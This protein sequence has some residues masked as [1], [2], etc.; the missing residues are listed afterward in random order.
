MHLGL[1]GASLQGER[2][3]VHCGEGQVAQRWKSVRTGSERSGLPFSDGPSGGK[4]PLNSS[5][6]GGGGSGRGEAG[7]NSPARELLFGACSGQSSQHT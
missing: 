4:S 7:L 6:R 3:L 1:T 2:R 5:I